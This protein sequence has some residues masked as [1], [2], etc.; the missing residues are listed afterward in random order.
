MSN[1]VRVIEDISI[2]L[3]SARDTVRARLPVRWK[4]VTTTACTPTLDQYEQWDNDP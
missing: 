4:T 3:R 1:G 2:K